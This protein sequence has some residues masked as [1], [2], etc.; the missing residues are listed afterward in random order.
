MNE[1]LIEQI[2]IELNIFGDLIFDYILNIKYNPD[3]ESKNLIDLL[4]YLKTI[5]QY[6]EYLK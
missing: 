1:M 6:S 4:D 5:N 2:K 3:I